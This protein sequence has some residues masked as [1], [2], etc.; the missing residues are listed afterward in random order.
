ML[1]ATANRRSLPGHLSRACSLLA[2][3]A[4]VIIAGCHSDGGVDP[5]GDS[6]ESQITA[7]FPTG[8]GG[9]DAALAKLKTLREKLAQNATAAA[10]AEA[11]GLVDL[12]LNAFRDDKLVGGTGASARTAATS[13][14]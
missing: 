3:A 13:P 5:D 1:L 7:L 12:T 2:S 11:L 9:Q 8:P 10:R 6:L 4:F 14:A